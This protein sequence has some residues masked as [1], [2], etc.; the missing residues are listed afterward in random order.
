MPVSQPIRDRWRV[1]ESFYFLMDR[2][3]KPPISESS[4]RITP[5]QQFAGE[6]EIR[7]VRFFVL[8]NRGQR[9]AGQ[10][11]KRLYFL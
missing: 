2:Q 4:Y 9:L 11:R 8:I 7:P 5:C 10:K 1:A 6:L 3:V